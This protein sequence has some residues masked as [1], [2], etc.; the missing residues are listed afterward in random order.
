MSQTLDEMIAVGTRRVDSMVDVTPDRV[1]T[2]A[3]APFGFRN[4]MPAQWDI[5]A[6]G[7]EQADFIGCLPKADDVIDDPG[8]I[9]FDEHCRRMHA[10]AQD[11]GK[12]LHVHTDQPTCPPRMEP[13]G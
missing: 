9:G 12:M 6:K 7:I 11:T 10:L 5:F 13:N 8:H 3:L 2:T 4:D 1:G